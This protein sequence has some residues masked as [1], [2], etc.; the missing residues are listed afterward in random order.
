MPSD[1]PPPQPFGKRRLFSG[2][3]PT[4][5]LHIGNWLGAVR[6]WVDLTKDYEAIYSIVN[7]HSITIDYDPSQMPQRILDTAT[8]VMACGVTPDSGA[9]LFVQSAVPEH[10]ELSWILSSVTPMGEL[11]RM[12]QFKDKSQ[13]H[14]QN[15]N[16]GLFAY[17]VLQTADIILYKATAVPVGEDQVQHLELAREI[18]RGFNRRF[19]QVFP[20]PQPVLTRARRILGL[21]GEA[22]MSKSKNN[23]VTLH[24][25]PDTMWEKLRVAKT[26]PARKR[27]KDPGDPDVCNVFS[28]HEFF[29]DDAQ[30]EELTSGCRSASIGCVDCKKV[31]WNGMRDTLAPIRERYLELKESPSTV[32][33][34]LESSAE[35][36]RS[37]ARETMAEVREAM[38]IGPWSNPQ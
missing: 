25:D 1:S 14:A 36:C 5:D 23:T 13:Q 10:T 16:A 19:G 29:T 27:L 22:K 21:D 4:G 28:L 38:G 9:R 2:I 6:N 15:I 17:P 3:Q 33:E 34:F 24:E 30:R 18:V 35:D 26:D 37:L 20:E 32:R 8:M 12:V 31:L 11:S 7:Y